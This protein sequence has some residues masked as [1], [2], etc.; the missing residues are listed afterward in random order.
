MQFQLFAFVFL[1]NT[2][3]EFV[4]NTYTSFLMESTCIFVSISHHRKYQHYILLYPKYYHQL[5]PTPLYFSGPDAGLPSGGTGKALLVWTSSKLGDQG[6][7]G[8]QSVSITNGNPPM[9]MNLQWRKK[10]MLRIAAAETITEGCT[11]YDGGE[12]VRRDCSPNFIIKIF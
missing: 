3:E 4:Q 8:F 5:P 10:T 2:C 12:L 1:Q 7:S 11:G 9:E 6:F